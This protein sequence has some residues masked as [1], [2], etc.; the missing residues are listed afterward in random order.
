MRT[1]FWIGLIIILALATL[2]GFMDWPP[3]PTL[4]L[5]K[6]TKE[7]RVREGLDLQ[8]GTRL[9]YQLDLAGI[10]AKDQ[11]QAIVSVKDVIDRR[12]NSLGVVEPNIYKTQTAGEDSMAVELPGVSN[13]E[14]A[15]NMIGKTAQLQFL[16]QKDANSAGSMDVNDWNKTALTGKHLTRA[17]VQFDQQNNNPQVGIEFNDEGKKLFA[18]ITKKNLNKPLAIAL[19]D[20]IISAPTVQTVIDDGKA[21]ITGK[22][23]IK[24]VKDLARL[25]NAGALPVPIKL[26]EQRNIGATLG[27]ESVQKSLIAGLIGMLLIFVFMIFHYRLPGLMAC[28]ALIVYTL[29]ALAIFKFIPVTLTLAG[30]AGFI[31]SIGMAVDANILIFERMRE[32][33]RFGKTI[34]QALEEGFERAWPSIRDSNVSSLITCSILYLTTTGLVRGFAVTLAIGIMV[35]MF[36]AITVSRSFLRLALRPKQGQL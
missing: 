36:T 31:L 25:L 3:G 19:D 17:D 34:N 28:F 35:S 4:R 21:V 11:Q 26:I 22:F 2:A 9:V 14:E 27:T 5:G 32:E 15:T 6:M 12:V 30:I 20:Q 7:I 23:T 10:S 16:E 33:K 29:I 24:E 13:V 1:K 8:G 18:E